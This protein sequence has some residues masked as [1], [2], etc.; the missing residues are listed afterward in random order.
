MIPR[1]KGDDATLR[2]NWWNSRVSGDSTPRPVSGVAMSF[3]NGNYRC[4]EELPASTVN[5]RQR[6]F[7]PVGRTRAVHYSTNKPDESQTGSPT[8]TEDFLLEHSRF[9]EQADSLVFASFFWA[10]RISKQR[11]SQRKVKGVLMNCPTCF[12]LE[13][14]YEAALSEYIEARSSEWFFLCPDVAARK[15]VDM[16]RMR[17]ELEEHRLDA[18]VRFHQ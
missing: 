2:F 1:S 8:F 7:N 11:L 6:S 3:P 16:E 10:T 4:R 18:C 13:R 12:E 17:Y 5:E 14:T 9:S 15:N